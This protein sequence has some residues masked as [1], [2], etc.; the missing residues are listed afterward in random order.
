MHLR[1][2][3]RH[4]MLQVWRTATL[5][6]SPRQLLAVVRRSWIQRKARRL[7]SSAISRLGYPYQQL[8][9]DLWL[10]TGVRVK[11]R[12]VTIAM[13]VSEETVHVVASARLLV[14]ECTVPSWILWDLLHMNSTLGSNQFCIT[15]ADGG[16]QIVSTCDCRLGVY[17]SSEIALAGK[18]SMHSIEFLIRHLYEQAEN[19]TSYARQ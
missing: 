8:S 19:W 13:A 6:L 5:I 2:R 1:A 17:S 14:N 9:P 10:A 12:N 3:L 16:C 18:R 7:A 15:G 4:S 11:Q